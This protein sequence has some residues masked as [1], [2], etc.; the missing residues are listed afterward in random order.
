M[1][2][3]PTLIDIFR[4]DIIREQI[5]SN[6]RYEDLGVYFTCKDMYSYFKK[7]INQDNNQID[8]LKFKYECRIIY[9]SN[10]KIP[11][12]TNFIYKILLNCS[13]SYDNLTLSTFV[14]N[15][16]C[17]CKYE[18]NGFDMKYLFLKYI[19]KNIIRYLDLSICPYVNDIY[20]ELIDVNNKSTYSYIS[21]FKISEIENSKIDEILTRSPEHIKFL[22]DHLIPNIGKYYLNALQSVSD[23][24]SDKKPD[25]LSSKNSKQNNFQY[26]KNQFVREIFE[27]YNLSLRCED[28]L[29]YYQRHD[30]EYTSYIYKKRLS[31]CGY[32]IEYIQRHDLI[33]IGEIYMI[34]FRCIYR[35]CKRDFEILQYVKNHSVFNIDELYKLS[36]D[37]NV[38]NIK[39]IENHDKPYIEELYLKVVSKNGD[40]LEYVKNHDLKRI[41]EIYEKALLNGGNAL[42]FMKNKNI[43]FNYNIFKNAILKYK[44]S[45]QYI[46]SRLDLTEKQ[47]IELI[48]LSVHW[49]TSP[50]HY[51]NWFLSHVPVFD[52][53]YELFQ[54]VLDRS[55][56]S[57]IHLNNKYFKGIEWLYI[58]SLRRCP[59]NIALIDNNKL[60]NID[61][62]Y[63]HSIELDLNNVQY[64]LSFNT[65]NKIQNIK[66]QNKKMIN[67]AISQKINKLYKYVSRGER[68]D[69]RLSSDFFKVV[70]S[71]IFDIDMYKLSR[72]MA[73]NDGSIESFENHDIDCI[74]D[75]YDNFILKD[76]LNLNFFKNHSV[77]NIESIYMKS[78]KRYPFYIKDIKNHNVSNISELYMIAVKFSGGL[79]KYV[80]N[81]SLPNIRKIYE[82]AI[83]Q[84]VLSIKYI[85]NFKVISRND[86][87]Q[88]LK[89]H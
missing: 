49:H 48:K 44:D 25:K 38:S 57:I 65:E 46:E 4:C 81:H 79:L 43:K 58:Y 23:K 37:M 20:H 11:I 15:T 12:M 21:Y 71:K 16:I 27:I 5:I 64:L 33:D 8:K 82:E 13:K 9:D 52:G 75:I 56:S 63:K 3:Q 87:L 74:E 41:Q 51:E 83:K 80:K 29:L 40:L 39:W 78:I 68:I 54:F 18:Y 85:K 88:L 73:N 7:D 17:R 1:E 61:Y 24:L 6:L 67:K 77:S 89:I 22:K 19:K 45:M 72:I 36:I 14:K 30:L 76:I 32:D 10:D 60:K 59:S 47:K 66:I 70:D 42:Q 69:E 50:K 26:V 53:I 28:M 2:S 62:L 35:N 86:I 31:I 34:A 55:P 84:D